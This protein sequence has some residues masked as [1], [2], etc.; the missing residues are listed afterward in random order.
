MKKKSKIHLLSLKF[1]LLQII[2]VVYDFRVE[3]Y[4]YEGIMSYGSNN[5]NAFE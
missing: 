1:F 2:I 3:N 4:S 5:L